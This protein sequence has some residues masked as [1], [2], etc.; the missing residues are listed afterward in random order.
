LEGALPD[1]YG[2]SADELVA[3][4]AACH[5]RFNAT[6]AEV[7]TDPDESRREDV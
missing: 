2:F 3:V 7:P 5:A 4:L 6:D 1:T